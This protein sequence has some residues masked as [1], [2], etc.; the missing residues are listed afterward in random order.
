MGSRS[1]YETVCSLMTS[2]E[3]ISRLLLPEA[4]R[5]RTSSS[6]S[7]SPYLEPPRV[8]TRARDRVGAPRRSKSS[9]AAAS[10]SA[11]ARRRRE[12]SIPA[13]SARGSARPRTERRARARCAAR[14]AVFVRALLTRHPRRA[15]PR[16]ARARRSHPASRSRIAPR[17]RVAPSLAVRASSVLARREG[18]LDQGGEQRRS[19]QRLSGFRTRAADRRERGVTPFERE[20]KLREAGLRLPAEAAR[21][22][23][24]LLRSCELALEP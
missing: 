5:R 2:L 21:L 6:R 23:V 11:P 7:E 13:Q 10:S 19:L 15:R 24:S 16:P 22:A 20:P 4:T 14:V 17:A 3:A 12:R 8:E 18:D 1:R 9:P